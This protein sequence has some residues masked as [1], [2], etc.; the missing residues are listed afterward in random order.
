MAQNTASRP[1]QTKSI[2]VICQGK[3]LIAQD[4]FVRLFY[5][6]KSRIF[7][8]VPIDPQGGDCLVRPLNQEVRLKSVLV[9][10]WRL[11]IGE[12]NSTKTPKPP[13]DA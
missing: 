13:R 1:K 8:V 10:F 11:V 9:S 5:T 7:F 6:V 3:C 12:R 2:H 4:T